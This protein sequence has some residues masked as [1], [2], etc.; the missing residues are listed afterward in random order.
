L[1]EAEVKAGKIKKEVRSGEK[2]RPLRFLYGS[3][4]SNN[5]LMMIKEIKR[6]RGNRLGAF[7]KI[8]ARGGGGE[9]L[10]SHSPAMVRRKGVWA[11]SKT[12]PTPVDLAWYLGRLVGET[13]QIRRLPGG[14]PK[15]KRG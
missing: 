3:H 15:P 7:L 12:T 13:D 5:N 1:E 10:P 14:G 4:A 11:R 2:K 8:S 6:R 9:R